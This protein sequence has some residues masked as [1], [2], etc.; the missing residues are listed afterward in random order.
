MG[1]LVGSEKMIAILGGRW[2]PQTAKEEGEKASKKCFNVSRGRNVLSAQTLEVSLLGV[3][4]VFRLGRD[5]RSM[6]N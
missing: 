2:L 6:D 4:T 1:T 5:A 3:G